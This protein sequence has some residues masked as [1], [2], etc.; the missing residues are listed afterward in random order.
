MRIL[1]ILVIPAEYTLTIW[2]VNNS[3]IAIS[4]DIML[5]LTTKISD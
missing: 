2:T 3:S 4:V 1:I 5:Q